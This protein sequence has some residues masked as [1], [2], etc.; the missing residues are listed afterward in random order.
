MR[1]EIRT[2]GL[3]SPAEA[4]TRLAA[5][6]MA[7][8][9]YDARV[10]VWD[11]TRS[12]LLIADADDA[13]GLRCLEQALRRGIAVMA[14]SQDGKQGPELAPKALASA[15]A[16]MLARQLAALL[17]QDSHPREKNSDG[18]GLVLLGT[19]PALA[20]SLLKASHGTSIILFNRRTSRVYARHES[21]LLVAQ[22]L[23]SESGWDFSPVTAGPEL[24]S[25]CQHS[26]ALDAFCVMAA[27]KGTGSFPEFASAHYQLTDWPDIG[28]AVDAPHIFTLIRLLQKTPIACSELI[29]RSGMDRDEA[30]ALLWAFQASGIL[31]ARE[32]LPTPAATPHTTHHSERGF[33]NKL[34]Q[35][36]GFGRR[37]Q[38]AGA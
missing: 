37:T 12:S 6:L 23:M 5:Q 16:A 36:F 10:S 34:M 29:Q 22:T 11:G 19:V 31:A 28:V 17:Q 21:D 30:T 20:S 4:R 7:A 27:L 14:L 38:E 13:Y 18:N 24:Q 32:A 3:A 26:M 2:A 35:H 33:L 9:G 8:L 1:I 15:P 25:L